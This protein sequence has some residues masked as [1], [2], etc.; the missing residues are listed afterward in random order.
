MI[1]IQCRA[2]LL[3]IEGTVSPV[4]FV[5]DVMFP[6]ARR[7]VESFLRDNWQDENVQQAVTLVGKDVG[8]ADTAAWLG[9]GDADSQRAV[10]RDAIYEL[11]D[12]DAKVT[13]LKQLQ[14]MIWRTGFECGELVSD[15]FP[16]VQPQLD[17]WKSAG[18][19][20]YIYSS[21]SIAAQR[22]FFGHTVAGD[23]L[24]RFS[25]F[26]DTTS[27]NKKES[28]SYTSIAS[29]IGL[30]PAS[31]CFISD[32]VAELDAAQAAGMQTVLRPVD[33]DKNTTHSSISSLAE[34]ACL[35]GENSVA[36]ARGN[37][38]R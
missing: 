37:E 33:N 4:A 18:L 35:L 25:G 28:A 15:L 12:G 29:G 32:V 19:D 14:G 20:L 1:E 2:V 8:Q 21:G 17:A 26:F 24:D 10:V 38:P 34:V 23:L 27:G 36:S 9:D 3:D 6:Y 31:I 7:H 13:G 16:D 30:P 11:M 22:L 5:F